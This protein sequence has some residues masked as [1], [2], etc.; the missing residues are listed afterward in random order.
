MVE[1]PPSVGNSLVSL[2]QTL[3]SGLLIGVNSVRLMAILATSAFLLFIAVDPFLMDEAS[4]KEAFRFRMGV[5]GVFCILGA[6]SWTQW[7]KAHFCGLEQ[8]LD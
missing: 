8:R 2:S 3:F 4:L 5:V 6:L 1:K 7:G